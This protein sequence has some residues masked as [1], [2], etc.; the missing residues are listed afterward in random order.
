MISYAQD[1]EDVVL[2]RGLHE[3]AVGRCI[4]VGAS[5]PVLRFHAAFARQLCGHP[6]AGRPAA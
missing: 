6:L 4:D 2:H 5:D 3:V 1:F